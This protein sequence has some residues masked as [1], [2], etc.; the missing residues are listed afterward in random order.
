MGFIEETG[1]AQYYRDARILPIY[2]GANG[3]QAM[4]L[5]FRKVLRDGGQEAKRYIGEMK[6]IDHAGLQAA[7]RDLEEVTDWVLKTGQDDLNIPASIGALYLR[8]FAT[9]AGGALMAQQM[10][11][12]R[13]ETGPFFETKVLTAEYYL[14]VLMPQ[15]SGLKSAIMNGAQAVLD[16]TPDQF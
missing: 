9:I 12:A 14:D 2:E 1:A 7:V 3:I 10:H 15:V 16:M 8:Q 5:V 6:T 11:A 13:Q 4:D